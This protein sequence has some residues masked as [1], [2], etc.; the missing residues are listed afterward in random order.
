MSRIMPPASTAPS[1]AVSPVRTIRAPAGAGHGLDRG[2]VRGGHLGRLVDD[3]H[4]IPG[5]PH[6]AP[7]SAVL[8]AAE[9]L[10]DVVRLG[11]AFGRQ[12]VAAHDAGGVGRER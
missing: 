10:G 2:Q 11:Q 8:Q 7:G 1:W 3:Q 9:E 6:S 12:A 5:Y 4:V